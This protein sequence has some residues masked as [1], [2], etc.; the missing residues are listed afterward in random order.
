MVARFSK[1]QNIPV[2][3]G[4]AAEIC[5]NRSQVRE[6]KNLLSEWYYCC[7]Y[8]MGQRPALPRHSAHSDSEGKK[9]MLLLWMCHRSKTGVGKASPQQLEQGHGSICVEANFRWNIILA[10]LKW[11]LSTFSDR[12]DVSLSNMLHFTAV[13][14]VLKKDMCIYF[15]CL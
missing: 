7:G 4:H 12:S 8:I 1:C 10:S 2:C 13:V 3:E 14:I 11:V 15:V 6:E 9:V 5:E